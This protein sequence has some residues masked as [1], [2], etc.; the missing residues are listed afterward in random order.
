MSVL[1][2]KGPVDPEGCQPSAEVSMNMG[3]TRRSLSSCLSGHEICI[4]SL[5]REAGK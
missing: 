5:H 2:F 4:I 3:L 1:L